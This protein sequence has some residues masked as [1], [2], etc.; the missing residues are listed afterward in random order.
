VL[1]KRERDKE[2]DRQAG[3]QRKRGEGGKSGTSPPVLL[4]RNKASKPVKRRSL[5]PNPAEATPDA[6]RQ[7][8]DSRIVD[9]QTSISSKCVPKTRVLARLFT[10]GPMD[11]PPRAVFLQPRSAAT[12]IRQVPRFP[13]AFRHHRC[14]PH[15]DGVGHDG[16][17][18]AAL[19]PADQDGAP[20]GNGGALGS[21]TVSPFFVTSFWIFCD[22]FY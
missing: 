12:M 16:G 13:A 9:E 18:R 21:R 8:S 11:R 1:E 5:P 17:V 4:A 19:L 15:P 6:R 3:R 22:C 10:A 20:H 2:R 7:T 14:R